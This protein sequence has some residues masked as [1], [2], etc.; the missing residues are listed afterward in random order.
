MVR[1]WRVATLFG[2]GIYVHPTFLLLPALV[3]AGH[4]AAGLFP[5]LYLLALVTTVFGC[6]VLHELGHALMA[7]H[8][9]IETLDITLYPIGGVARLGRP[10]ERPTEELLIALAGPAVNVAIV[11]LLIPVLLAGW[12]AGGFGPAAVATAFPEGWALALSFAASVCLANFVLVAFNLLPA[13]PMDGGRVLRALLSYRLGLVRATEVAV[14]VGRAVLL[15]A[16]ALL[17]L[18]IPEVLSAN[19]MLFAIAFFVFLAGQW[20]LRGVRRMVAARLVPPA[21]V[22]PVLQ[23]GLFFGPSGAVGPGFSGVT[24]DQH[25]GVGMRWLDGQVVATFILPAE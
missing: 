2:I 8:Y 14:P 4:Y 25:S 23:H 21:T 15:T 3:V 9:G 24:W 18:L 16:L 17:Y 7:R 6:V 1:S 22:V 10:P 5:V 12:L 11:A 13:F 20:E 19:K